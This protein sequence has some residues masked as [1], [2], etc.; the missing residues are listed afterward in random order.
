MDPR[1]LSQRPSPALG[2]EHREAGT[3]ASDPVTEADVAAF[4]RFL[5]SLRQAREAA[6]LSLDDMAA[7]S[8]IDKARLSRLETGKVPEPRPS[9]L[10]RYARA[11]GKRLAWS[12]ADDES[13]AAPPA[14]PVGWDA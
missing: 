7:R 4:Q 10:A 2:R 5:G 6:G 11:V 3:I 8:G 13:P 12:L 9:T 14:A 1:E